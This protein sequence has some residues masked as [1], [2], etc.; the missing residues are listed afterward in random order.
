[1]ANRTKRT[2]RAR[3]TFLQTLRDTCNVSEACRAAGFGR[4]A[5]YDWRKEDAAFAASWDEA[6]AVAIDNLEGLAYRRAMSGQS[7]RLVEILL[8]AHRSEKYV[9]KIK[10]EHSGGV[11]MVAVTDLDEQL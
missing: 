10:T 7:D 3:E 4:S 9:E 6:E 8:K 1:M 11:R 2:D 5:A